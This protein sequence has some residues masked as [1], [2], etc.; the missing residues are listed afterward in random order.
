MLP[1]SG[2]T[3]GFNDNVTGFLVLLPIALVYSYIV[4]VSDDPGRPVVGADGAGDPGGPSRV[5]GPATLTRRP[6][7]QPGASDRHMS[8][9]HCQSPGSSNT[10]LIAA[11][12]PTTAE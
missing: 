3:S 4:V 8:S 10:I 1:F 9:A 6:R 2:A 12:E 7:A 5:D 11:P